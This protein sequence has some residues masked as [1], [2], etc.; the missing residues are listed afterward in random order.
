MITA[1]QDIETAVAKFQER[2]DN[3]NLTKEVSAEL[4][5]EYQLN[6][7]LHTGTLETVLEWTGESGMDMSLLRSII[8]K[9]L[10]LKANEN[11]E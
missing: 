9:H 8:Y 10:T 11:F 1:M 5:A 4:R 6:K 3:M 7:K 2:I